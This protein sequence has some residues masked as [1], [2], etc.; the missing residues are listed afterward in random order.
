MENATIIVD[1]YHFCEV[2]HRPLPQ[3]KIML[4]IT[5]CAKHEESIKQLAL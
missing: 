2:C 5:L 1:K 3:L 4:R